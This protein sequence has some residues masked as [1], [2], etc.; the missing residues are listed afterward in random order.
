MLIVAG[1]KLGSGDNML[2]PPYTRWMETKV[3]M[4]WELY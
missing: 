3:W 2:C 4:A 1:V